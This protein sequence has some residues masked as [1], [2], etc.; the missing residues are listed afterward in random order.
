MAPLDRFE[1]D[2]AA[3]RS[4][5]AEA[6][7]IVLD[8]FELATDVS[9]TRWPDRYMDKRGTLMWKS[10]TELLEEIEQSEQSRRTA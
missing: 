4:V 3:M 8:G 7:R 10:V 9:L 1:H 6:S 5:M 2:V